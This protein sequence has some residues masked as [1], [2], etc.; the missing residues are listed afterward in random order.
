MEIRLFRKYRLY[1]IL[2]QDASDKTKFSLLYITS[3]IL[4]NTTFYKKILK[5]LDRWVRYRVT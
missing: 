2:K 5:F 1:G 3:I 4:S